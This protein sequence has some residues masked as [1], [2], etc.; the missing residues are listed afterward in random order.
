MFEYVCLLLYNMKVGGF[1]LYK[2]IFKDIY[3]FCIIYKVVK[4]CFLKKEKE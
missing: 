4:S 2:K 3:F 1:Y